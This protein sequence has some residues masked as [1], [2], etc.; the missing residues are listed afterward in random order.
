MRL[1]IAHRTVYTYD[2]PIHYALQRLRLTPVNGRLQTIRQWSLSIAGADHEVSFLDAF[3]NATWLVSAHGEPHEIAITA[4]GEVDTHD[5]AGVHGPHAGHAPLW[6]FARATAL[7]APG[8][9]TEALAA[10]LGLGAPLDRLHRLNEAV[11]AAIVWVPGSTA[12][13][14]SGEESLALGQGV[15]QDHAHAFVTAARLLGYPARYISGYLM[16][17]GETHQAA[18]HAWA[19]AHVDGL[20]WVGFDPANRQSPDGRYI[21]LACGRD[22]RDAMPV[23]GIVL[24]A[25]RE[26]L[27]VSVSVEQ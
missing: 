1:T 8:P 4:A 20:G 26:T 18:S 19:E 6:L 10:G 16:R 14:M 15:C 13:H 21:R 9:R 2:V 27:A 17:D 23:S 3:G 22:Y 24:G 11:A 25:S 5:F 12:V 7:T